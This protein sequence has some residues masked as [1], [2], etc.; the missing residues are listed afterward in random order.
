[1]IIDAHAHIGSWPTVKDTEDEILESMDR[2]GVVFSLV[3]DC[4]ASEY[5]SMHKWPIHKQTQ[6][7]ALRKTL[8]FVK[9]HPRKLGAAVWINPHNEKVDAELKALIEANR[10]YIYAIKMHPWESQIRIDSPKLKPY[11]EL[12]REFGLP[13]LVHTAQDKYSDVTILAAVAKA[14]PDLTFIAAHM[15]L[16]SD[17]KSALAALRENPNL[18]GDT[19]WVDMK[20]AKKALVEIGS[21][22]IMFGTDNPID[23]AET[24]ANPIYESYYKNKAKLPGSLYHN[25]MYRNAAKVYKIPLPTKR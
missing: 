15:Q 18:Y 16:L 8:A 23:G 20:I 11:L 10:Q 12:A 17:N 3:S 2:F 22:R 21:D 9:R 1:M 25:L 19:A 4:D 14:N 24:L 6:I 5:P 13:L 7:A